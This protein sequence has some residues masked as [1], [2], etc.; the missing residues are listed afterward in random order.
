MGVEP[1][2][3]VKEVVVGVVLAVVRGA[4][5]RIRA[6]IA[7]DRPTQLRGERTMGPVVCV[8]DHE[9]GRAE[10]DGCADGEAIRHRGRVRGSFRSGV[11]P[12]PKRSNACKWKQTVLKLGGFQI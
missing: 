7:H 5:A 11:F 12:K 2:L 10:A 3:E 4:D 6:D 8:V 9:A 1:E